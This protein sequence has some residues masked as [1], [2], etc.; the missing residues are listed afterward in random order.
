MTP[1]W[2]GRARIHTHPAM[3]QHLLPFFVGFSSYIMVQCSSRRRFP[4]KICSCPL[5]H[6]FTCC[7][8]LAAAACNNTNNTRM[9]THCVWDGAEKSQVDKHIEKLCVGNKAHTIYLCKSRRAP[10]T[11]KVKEAHH[12][13]SRNAFFRCRMLRMPSREK[14]VLARPGGIFS[15]R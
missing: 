6:M 8:F 13:F 15:C 9:R 5:A 11:Q 2:A 1:G 10:T 4:P 14:H 3:R 7:C 12:A